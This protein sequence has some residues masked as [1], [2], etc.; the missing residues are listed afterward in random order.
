MNRTTIYVEG[1]FYTESGQ[2]LEIDSDSVKIG[3]G[4]RITGGCAS[5]NGSVFAF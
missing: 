4:I 3:M 5:N 1:L 2:Q